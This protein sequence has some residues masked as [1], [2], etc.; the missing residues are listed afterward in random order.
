MLGVLYDLYPVDEDVVDTLR[1][2]INTKFIAGHIV[3][4][5]AR[6]ATHFFGIEDYQIGVVSECDS[7]AVDKTEICRGA[8]RDPMHGLLQCDHAMLTHAFFE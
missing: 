5:V 7:S 4:V 1:V 3:P 8:I 2:G 6:A